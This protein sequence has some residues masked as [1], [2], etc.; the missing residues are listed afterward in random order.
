MKP[1]LVLMLLLAAGLHTAAHATSQ[2]VWRC[3]PEGRSYESQPCKDGRAIELP[4][5]RPEAEVLAAQRVAAAEQGLAR[6]LRNERLA[7]EREL[8]SRGPGLAGFGRAAPATDIKPRQDRQAAKSRT[9]QP[10]TPGATPGATPVR[11][12]RSPEAGGTSPRAARASQRTP[13]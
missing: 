13:G 12:A 9:T 11:Q 6:Q 2:T 8:H 7:R 5:A 10:S 1:L 3:G 4:G